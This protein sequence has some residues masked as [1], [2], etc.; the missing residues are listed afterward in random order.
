MAGLL[1]VCGGGDVDGVL[2][3][4]S[5]IFSQYEW[6]MTAK[7]AEIPKSLVRDA[8]LFVMCCFMARMTLFVFSRS[9]S[10]NVHG[11]GVSTCIVSSK[12]KVLEGDK[13]KIIKLSS[14][15]AKTRLF[16]AVAGLLVGDSSPEALRFGPALLRRLLVRALF[17]DAI[18]REL[19]P[20]GGR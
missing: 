19:Y 6:A 13:I 12:S 7:L 11:I 18:P 10:G 8:V 4:N 15:D 14:L 2:G 16:L 5:R 9:Q 1:L 17:L 20:D 3:C